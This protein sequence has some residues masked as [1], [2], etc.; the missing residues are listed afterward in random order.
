[1]ACDNCHTSTTTPRGPSLIGIYGGKRPISGG[2]TATADDAYLREAILKPA[3]KL[4][5]GY[6]PTMPEYAGQLSEEDVINLNAYIK[7]LNASSAKPGGVA[8]VQKGSVAGS[9]ATRLEQTSPMAFGQEG[10]RNL[11]ETNL[12]ETGAAVNASAGEKR[13]DRR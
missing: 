1:L 9:S 5:A 11:G 4:T 13:M 12:N 8:A 6:G 2:E 10:F 3:T 7:S